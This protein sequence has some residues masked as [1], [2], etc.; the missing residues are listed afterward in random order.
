MSLLRVKTENDDVTVSVKDL[1]DYLDLL[2]QRYRR[3]AKASRTLS[4]NIQYRYAA[5]AI[6]LLSEGVTLQVLRYLTQDE[7]VSVKDRTARLIK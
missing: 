7:A 2:A 3:N 1:T 5:R 4:A 6:S